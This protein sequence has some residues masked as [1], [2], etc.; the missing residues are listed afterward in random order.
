MKTR[1]L[2]ALIAIVLSAVGAFVLVN[3]VQ[4]ADLRAAEGA[5]FTEVYV[6][7]EAMPS[8]TLGEDVAQFIETKEIPALAI[9]EGGVT[10]LGTLAGLVSTTDQ[11]PGEQLLAARWADPTTVGN[12]LIPLPEGMQ[13]ITVVLSAERV[14]GGTVRPGD[15]VGVFVSDTQGK[16]PAVGTVPTVVTG[17]G[18]T[19]QLF[20]RALVIGVQPG[21]AYVANPTSV[22]GTEVPVDVFSVTFAMNTTDA[23]KLVWAKEW[24]SLWLSFEPEDNTD[25]EQ[26]VVDGQDIF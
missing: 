11:L 15:T 5:K 2:A 24:A 6:V 25:S 12:G 22:E 4:S 23:T 8:G 1:I 3:Y 18:M 14:V 13:A 7:T 26:P 19:T 17:E 16:V 21:T 20:H 10:D 9:V